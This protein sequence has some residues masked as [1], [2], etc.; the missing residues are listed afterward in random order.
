MPT[1][2]ITWF[3]KTNAALERVG[4][5]DDEWA[6]PPPPL[7]GPSSQGTA[8]WNFPDDMEIETSI[9]YITEGVFRFTVGVTEEG[10]VLADTSSP[11]A[12][13]VGS[14]TTN[15]PARVDFILTPV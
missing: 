10:D 4:D 11:D 5:F 8:T 3:N 9:V 14:E 1:M 2:Q 15:N 13:Q 12:F 7:L 6:P